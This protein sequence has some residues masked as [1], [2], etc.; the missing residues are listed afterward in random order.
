[1]EACQTVINVLA[2]L[3]QDD[4]G[5]DQ[6]AATEMVVRSIGAAFTA[7]ATDEDWSVGWR[8]DAQYLKDFIERLFLGNE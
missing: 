7:I 6:S 2:E 4:P 8:Q 1:M 3:H 5:W